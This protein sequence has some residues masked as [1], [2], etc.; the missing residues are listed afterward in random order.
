M[1]I[2][3]NDLYASPSQRCHV[4]G[5]VHTTEHPA[6]ASSKSRIRLTTS[7]RISHRLLLLNIAVGLTLTSSSDETRIESRVETRNCPLPPPAPR[8][9][10]D[11]IDHPRFRHRG[12]RFGACFA[13][14]QD[15]FKTHSTF[16][17]FKIN[18]QLL[19]TSIPLNLKYIANNRCSSGQHSVRL[20]LSTLPVS[21][22]SDSSTPLPS[23]WPPTISTQPYYKL[24]GLRA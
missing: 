5:Y 20:N 9:R 12:D 22:L 18:L 14:S 11:V 17:L 3:G 6:D 23:E 13:S 24:T 16:R 2:F 7:E 21:L 19:V 10:L 15:R 1:N 8:N 4:S